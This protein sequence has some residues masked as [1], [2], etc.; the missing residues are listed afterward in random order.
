MKIFDMSER[1]IFMDITDVIVIGAGPAGLNA[2]LYASRKELSVKIISNDIGGQ[3]LLTSEIENY[4]GF[5]SISG[6]D[7][8]DKMEAHVRKYPVE[9][10]TA[11][12]MN[13]EK[14]EDGNFV[15]HLDDGNSVVGKVCIITAGKHSRTLDIP[16]EAKFTGRG[17]SYCATCDA[18]FYRN[19]TVAIVGGGDSA[20]QAAVEL[21]HL[22]PKVYLVVRSRIKAAEIMVKRME[23]LP[24]VEA[25]IGYVPEEVKGDKKVNALVVKRKSDGEERELAVD[26]VFVEAGGIPNNSYLPE[27]VKT[28]SMGEIITNKDGETNIP[29]LYAAGDVTD[30]K[31]KQIIIA[32]GEGAAAAL[33]AHDY[34]L[35]SGK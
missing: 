21:G 10:I 3:M 9:F 33:A 34:L 1:G 2:A 35:R 31:N 13:L 12:V 14:N 24:N 23:E 11:A 20:V 5:E 29:G 32:V 19:K 26:G 18:P 8:A 6:F 27:D 28:N 22:C 16:G 25:L 15:L 30:C 7:L 4:L 17:V